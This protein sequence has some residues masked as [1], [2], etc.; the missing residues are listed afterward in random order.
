MWLTLRFTSEV[1]MELLN[2]QPMSLIK[3]VQGRVRVLQD[4]PVFSQS[5]QDLRCVNEAISLLPDKVSIH[6]ISLWCYL[7]LDIRRWRNGQGSCSTKI[8]EAKMH[9]ANGYLVT[10]A[11][12]SEVDF[13]QK[14]MESGQCHTSS[15]RCNLWRETC[16]G[17]HSGSWESLNDWSLW[18]RYLKLP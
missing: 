12:I 7:P 17:K 4:S 18:L 16:V 1:W 5:W 6:K 15:H 13:S 10:L 11:S 2:A 14:L 3:E 8:T 9:T